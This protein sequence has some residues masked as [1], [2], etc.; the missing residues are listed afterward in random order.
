[1]GLTAYGRQQQAALAST[2]PRL[3]TEAEMTAEAVEQIRARVRYQKELMKAKGHGIEEDTME[4]FR[5]LNITFWVA[6]PVCVASGLYSLFFDVHPHRFE[7]ELPE[8]MHVRS[9][10]F[11]WQC[12][13]CDFFD[14]ACWKK[15]RA[16][17]A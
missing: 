13:D 1:M 4:M 3:G 14:T 10:E 7:G 6:V 5:W 8:Y 12:S 16:E 2:V 17:K 11:P 9:K 15:C